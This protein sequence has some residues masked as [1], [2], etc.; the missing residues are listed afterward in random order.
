MD[1]LRQAPALN[2]DE[3]VELARRVYGLE[4][5]ASPLPSERD[6]NFALETRGG[7]RFV[8]KMANAADGRGLLE[9]QN[10]AIEHVGRKTPLCQRVIPAVD[11]RPIADAGGHAVRLLTWLPGAPIA[12][13]SDPPPA[14]FEDLGRAVAELDAALDDFDHAD[15]HRP[16]YWDLAGGL[17]LVRD[18]TAS[19]S[20]ARTRA[21][22]GSI[23]D[24]VQRRDGGRLA[25][26]PRA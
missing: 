24:A 6:Q 17:A 10:A 2:L 19:V 25:L 1:V 3:A 26:L 22:I 5:A 7:E 20:E 12:S 13:L 18:L 11:G 9:A 23:A 8:L 16:F 4:T 21:L 14:L 15:A